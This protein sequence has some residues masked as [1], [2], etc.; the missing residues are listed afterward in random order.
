LPGKG[1]T[2]SFEI[3][4]PEA[5]A[6]GE[7]AGAAVSGLLE[8]LGVLVVEDNP[9]NRM[10]VTRMLE[11]LG[12]FVETAE[13][14]ERG[15]EA[16]LRGAFDLILMDIQMPGIDGME[17]TRQ[18]RQS[19][20]MAAQTPII[21]LTA[22]VLT[23]QREAYLASGMDGVVGKPVSPAALLA[24]IARVAAEEPDAEPVRLT[25]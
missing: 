24:E 8:G 10:I 19:G 3:A 20:S 12:A 23:H 11:G 16:A 4:A 5:P 22:N 21:A 25:G 6:P 13:D 17:A 7:D 18:I 1:S 14:G 15:V 9:T 2:F